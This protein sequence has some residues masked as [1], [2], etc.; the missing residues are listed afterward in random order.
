[1]HGGEALRWVGYE[2]DI[3]GLRLGITESRAQWAV[4]WCLRVARDGR[5][6][7]DDFRAALGRL[8][9]IT[10]ALEFER[11]FLAP[12]YTFLSLVSADGTRDLPLYVTTVLTHLAAR[13][14]ARR[15]YPS[16]VRR[17]K[18]AEAFRVDAHA[19]GDAIGVG[20]WMPSR[21]AQGTLDPAVSRWFSVSLS[22]DS[23]PW[24]YCR[25]EPFRAIA[26]LEALGVLLALLA[27][28]GE[29]AHDQDVAL[30]I[31]GVT[32]NRGNAYVLDRLM[33]T[34]FPLC[35]V[36]MELAAQMEKKN[37]R[38]ALDW[39]PRELNVEADALANGDASLFDANLRVPLDLT[40]I[41]W[42]VLDKLM[43][44]GEEQ[45]LAKRS[46]PPPAPKA[47]GRKK[48]K[49]ARLRVTDPW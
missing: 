8:G 29:V 40:N 30:L 2:V 44:H 34:R 15:L 35:A 16:A 45:E 13:F 1:V 7:L 28:S 25:G 47:G 46:R 17:V 11:P 48:P 22:R 5:V 33:S 6:R 31:P 38:V 14:S 36:V 39:C 19:D 18:S 4:T 41:D 9:F 12:L 32:D 23:A 42:I 43:K 24:A 21:N 3:V 49:W 26:A 20:G 10:G 37:A 27:F